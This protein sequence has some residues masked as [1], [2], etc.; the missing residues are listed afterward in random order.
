MN[1]DDLGARRYPR[2]ESRHAV[3]V[4]KLTGAV[5]EEFAPTKT[6]AVGGCCLVT[7]EPLGKDSRVE[8]LINVDHR[9]VTARG[10]V[11]YEFPA[12][13]GRTETG[14][15]FLQLDDDAETAI[16]GLFA[17]DVAQ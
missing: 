17:R 10:R 13:D 1:Y 9:V 12:G 11:V 5:L 6:I 14:I 4:R 8:L 16:A 15:E 2:L 3:L 7:D